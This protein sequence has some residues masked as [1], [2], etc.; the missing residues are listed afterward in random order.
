[1]GVAVVEARVAVVVG[2][3]RRVAAA[4]Q[5]VA[6]ADDDGRGRRVARSPV[7][8]PVLRVAPS[9]RGVPVPGL[10]AELSAQAVAQ[11]AQSGGEHLADV[12]RAEHAP[13]VAALVAVN[14]RAEGFGGLEGVGG[15]ARRVR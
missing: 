3:V 7:A 6:V 8:P 10:V 11:G 14:A 13:R 15:S 12:A 4:R 9:A 1:F 5:P 2:L